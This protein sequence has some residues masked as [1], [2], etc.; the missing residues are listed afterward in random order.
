MQK[1]GPR[2]S[3]RRWSTYVTRQ[4][5]VSNRRGVTPAKNNMQRSAATA[6]AEGT[7]HPE[8]ANKSVTW[9]KVVGRKE[10]E[11]ARKKAEQENQ[12]KVP[13]REQQPR[14]QHPMTKSKRRGESQTVKPPRRAAVAIT[15]APGS[16]KRAK[17]S[18]PLP[19]TKY[20]YQ[21]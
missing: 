1:A 21:I 2:S 19:G 9:A 13:P 14:K 11:A 16:G 5:R 7:S 12:R 15:V 6:K 3:S 10:K 8:T 18:L 4:C 17:M 20:T